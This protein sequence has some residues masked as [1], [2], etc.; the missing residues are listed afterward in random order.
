MPAHPLILEMVDAKGWSGKVR[1]V[2]I[3]GREIGS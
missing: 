2:M 3:L 1:K